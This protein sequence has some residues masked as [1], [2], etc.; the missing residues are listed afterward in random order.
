MHYP[1]ALWCTTILACN[2]CM[3]AAANHIYQCKHISIAMVTILLYQ[4]L[5]CEHRL[6]P[7]ITYEKIETFLFFIQIYAYYSYKLANQQWEIYFVACVA[8]FYILD[9]KIDFKVLYSRTAILGSVTCSILHPLHWASAIPWMAALT[10]HACVQSSWKKNIHAT[11]IYKSTHYYCWYWIYYDWISTYHYPRTFRHDIIYFSHIIAALIV[12]LA[13]IKY[14]HKK[15]KQYRIAHAP[16]Q[17]GILLPPTTELM[18]KS[19]F[20]SCYL[21]INDVETSFYH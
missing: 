4:L 1:R 18:K 13:A 20:W 14:K 12:I 7:H 21:Q 10:Y 16:E 15:E 6:Q 2:I 11:H 5:V 3:I 19:T 8:L 17:Y 9:R